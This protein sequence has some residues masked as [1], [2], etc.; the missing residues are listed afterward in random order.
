[1]SLIKTH[2]NLIKKICLSGIGLLA[3][4]LLHAQQDPHLRREG[5][6]TRFMVDG[7]PFLMLSGELGNSTS[8]SME[9]LAPRF[10]QLKAM[11]LNSVIATISWEQFEPKEGVYDYTLID[12]IIAEAEKNNLK[13]AIVWFG[14]W[15]NGLSNY[16]PLWVK[17]DLTRFYRVRNKWGDNT[18]TISPTCIAARDADAKAYA[19]LM[20][21][22]K[23]VDKK[24]MVIVMQV[25]NEMGCFS[26]IDYSEQSLKL[27]AE[28]VPA[29]LLS[30]MVQNEATL[31]DDLKE[32]W[33]K[34]G[35]KTR[36]T[37]KEV[38]GDNAD[39][40]EFFMAWQYASYVQFG[41][42]RG[43]E[44]Y[45]IPMYVNSWQKR[46]PEQPAGD[47]PCGGPVYRVIDIYKAAAP[48]ID[49]CAP[50]I[51]YTTFREVCA[52]YVRPDNPLFIPECTRDAGKAFYVFSE[53]NA[54]C[55]APFAIEEGTKDLEFIAGYGVLKS[56]LPT[57]LQYQ[58]TGKMRGWWRQNDEERFN[59]T[60]G[61]YEVELSCGKNSKAYGFVIQTA[62][63][64]FLVAS[65]NTR[66]TFKSVKK[67]MRAAVGSVREVRN[68]QGK[69]EDIRW[70]NG[71]EGQ[72]DG[73]KAYG[74]TV[75]Y[76]YTE[77]QKQGDLPPQPVDGATTIFSTNSEVKQ[78]RE[79]GVYMVQVYTY[80]KK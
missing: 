4:S 73:V 11:N 17:S 21:R 12:G 61:D 66:M 46:S 18:P 34:A 1:M 10:A 20:A 74:R 26:D 63:G 45:N 8:S 33:I 49:L 40:K 56:L 30:Y 60:M 9:S 55:F 52:R 50:D 23:R 53:L 69:W 37:W 14:S 2:I 76:G 79:P 36:G 5:D 32:P 54:L 3:A 57:I 67:D 19:A 58:G 27:F 22:I 39:A 48:A 6:L 7:R 68:V 29:P 16:A 77:S 31:K 35:K 62:P 41:G 65:F 51:Y 71:D 13:V 47:Y 44:Q 38:F 78:V 28:P 59:F 25:Q 24:K 42:Q 64:E 72:T 70:L 80:P 15:K 43:K 75:A